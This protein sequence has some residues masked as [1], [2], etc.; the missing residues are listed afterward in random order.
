MTFTTDTHTKLCYY[1]LGQGE[2]DYVYSR[3]CVEEGLICSIA[4]DAVGYGYNELTTRQ[5]LTTPVS[6]ASTTR[7]S[8]SCRTPSFAAHATRPCWRSVGDS[9]RHPPPS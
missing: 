8:T 5:S 6:A 7:P 2:L 1:F 3:L 4:V 9:N